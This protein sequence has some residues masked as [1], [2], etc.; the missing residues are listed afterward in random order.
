MRKPRGIP[1][2]LASIAMDW[3]AS[4]LKERTSGMRLRPA[5]AIAAGFS[6]IL[7]GL[8][9]SA[10]FLQAYVV[11]TASMNASI[12]AGD[13]ILVS[14]TRDV[15]R[16]DLVSFRYPEDPRVTLVKRVIA[17]AGDRIRL[18]DRQVILNGHALSEP[19][20]QHIMPAVDLYRDNFPENSPRVLRPRAQQMLTDHR[21]NGEI[22][23]PPD[24]LFVLGDNRDVSLDSRYWGFV[25]KENVVGKPVLVYWSYAA[26]PEELTGGA[27]LPRHFLSGTRWGRTL[28]RLKSPRDY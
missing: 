18:A 17:I 15:G 16:G 11:P 27:Q 22:I 25:P 3:A 10:N 7:I 26:T 23:V 28:L 21:S 5:R 4:A 9:I 14:K 13:H 20:V 1:G 24:S 12:Q 19:Y 8:A 2:F 6:A